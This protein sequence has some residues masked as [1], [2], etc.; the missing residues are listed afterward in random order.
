MIFPRLFTCPT[1]TT[2]NFKVGKK[3]FT[4]LHSFL[5]LKQVKDWQCRNSDTFAEFEVNVVVVFYDDHLVT[6]NIPLHLTR[7]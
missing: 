5:I 7:F 3:R 4:F 2:N 1:L 6:E